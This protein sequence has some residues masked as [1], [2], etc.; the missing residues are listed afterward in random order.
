MNL[1]AWL[2]GSPPD[3]REQAR[4]FEQAL[5]LI[6]AVEYWCRALPRA[7]ELPPS[8]W[9]GT[10]LVS[11]A[12]AVV[13]WAPWRRTGLLA[14]AVAH[15][16]VMAIEFPAS[17]NHAYLELIFLLLLAFVDTARSKERR[18]FLR[19]GRWIVCVVLA[20]SGIQ[21]IAHGYYTHGQF[22][23]YTLSI[24]TYRAVLAPLLPTA[25]AARLA[26]LDGTV[27]AGPY[28]V[29]SALFVGVSR[30]VCAAEIALAP[31]LVLPATRMLALV[32]TVLL[33][34]AIEAG[35]REVF[36]GLVMINAVLLFGPASAQRLFVLV[37]AATLAGLLLIRTGVLPEVVFN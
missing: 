6:V 33:L 18:L 4:S 10:G 2:D 23:S 36:F 19:A 17:G 24:E 28:R 22:L 8:L 31:L 21:K 29:S 13:L 32:A 35:A 25:E 9:A 16:S 26:A 7:A 5:V 3:G 37:V 34:L 20:A 14:L 27:G 1:A 15:A 30:G 12:A 11:V